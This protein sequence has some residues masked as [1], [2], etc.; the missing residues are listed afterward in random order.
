MNKILLTSAFIFPAF[1]FATN[2]MPVSIS[3]TDIMEQSCDASV[4]EKVLSGCNVAPVI[5]VEKKRRYTI[6]KTL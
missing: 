1:A 2:D 3:T 6:D 4:D 5:E